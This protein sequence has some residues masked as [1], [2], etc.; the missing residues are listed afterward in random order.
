MLST[1]RWPGFRPDFL[2]IT[3]EP[4]QRVPAQ[5]SVK[6]RREPGAPGC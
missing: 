5:V 3:W 1:V 4:R 6:N 2:A